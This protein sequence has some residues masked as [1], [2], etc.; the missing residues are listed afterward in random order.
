MVSS[1]N[2]A[3]IIEL[4]GPGMSFYLPKSEPEQTAPEQTAL[5]VR[6]PVVTVNSLPTVATVATG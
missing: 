6:L 4:Y 2:M 3:S 5:E 1:D